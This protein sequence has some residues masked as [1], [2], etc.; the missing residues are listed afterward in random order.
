MLIAIEGLDGAGK[1][2]QA[3]RL[4]AAIRGAG[5]TCAQVAFP[6]YGE[7][8][9][10]GCISQYLN[11]EFGPMQGVSPHFVALLYA[12]DRRLSKDYLNGLR[13]KHDVVVADRYVSSN[14][15]YQGARWS[16]DYRQEFIDWLARLEY[17][18]NALRPAELTL[19]LDTSPATGMEMVAR[20]GARDYTDL[21]ADLHER[22]RAFL[23]ACHS[24]YGALCAQQ[25]R[26]RWA[27]VCCAGGN[28]R[29]LS[30]EAIHME[31]WSHVRDLLPNL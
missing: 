8:W 22:N 21:K 30:I 7:T 2:T 16:G 25:Y 20:K 6:R 29:L 18:V 13:Q 26:S 11:G 17:D 12:E 1:R 3:E 31:V 27:K 4:V 5:L 14:L 24:V 10:A 19:L 23:D 9:A 15:A 28:G